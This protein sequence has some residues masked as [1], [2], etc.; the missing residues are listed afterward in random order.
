MNIIKINIYLYQKFAINL[1]YIP[2]LKDS[3]LSIG[4][5]V[6]VENKKTYFSTEL[7]KELEELLIN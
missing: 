3:V 1:L 7:G 6:K 5:C 4:I 2:K